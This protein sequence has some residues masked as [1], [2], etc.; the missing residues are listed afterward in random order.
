MDALEKAREALNTAET[1][2][3]YEDTSTAFAA[4]T[5]AYAA[6]AQAEQLKRIADALTCDS[7]SGQTFSIAESLHLIRRLIDD[8]RPLP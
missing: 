1:L 7:S 3:K 6:I 5:Q 4:L 2:M 8:G